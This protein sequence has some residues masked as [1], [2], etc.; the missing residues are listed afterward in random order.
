MAAYLKSFND[1]SYERFA[2]YTGTIHTYIKVS[3]V[4]EQ[5][6]EVN[7]RN[8]TDS[9]VTYLFLLY[10]SIFNQLNLIFFA[11]M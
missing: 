8:V 10:I 6:H 5:K 11:L 1:L 2:Q 7:R 4:F 3:I 9:F